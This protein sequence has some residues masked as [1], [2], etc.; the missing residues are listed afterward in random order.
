MK[1]PPP[2]SVSGTW[3][4][5]LFTVITAAASAVESGAT[6]TLTG[7]VSNEGTGAFLPGALVRIDG[8]D[9]S[10][11]TERDGSYLLQVPP[12]THT[13]VASFSGLD[14]QSVLVTTGTGAASVLNFPLTSA[15]YKMAKFVV[16]SEREG[17]ALALTLQRQADNVKNV[18][19]SD[20][21]GSLAGNPG[22]LLQRVPGV[23]AEHVGGDIRY[24]SIRGINPDLSA[25][26]IDGNRSASISPDR[27]GWF[28]NLNADPI[29]SMEVIKAPTPD[30]DADSIGGTINLRS[31]SGFDVKGRRITYSLGGTIAVRRDRPH[32]AVT[33]SYADVVGKEERLGVSFTAGFREYLAVMDDTIH[34]FQNTDADPAYQWRLETVERKNLRGRWGGGLKLDYK[35]SSEAS[36]FTNFTYA[37]NSEDNFVITHRTATAQTVATLN[38][39]GAPTGTGA[40]L[41]NFTATRTEARP[42]AASIAE[43]INLHRERTATVYTAQAGGR[44]RSPR[45][46]VD[47]DGSYSYGEHF[48]HFNRVT[49][50][51]RGVGWVLDRTDRSRWTPTVTQI[52]GPDTTNLDNYTSNVFDSVRPNVENTIYGAQF[53]Y[54]RK[55]DFTWPSY[56]KTGL[57]F[58][59]EENQRSNRDRRWNHVGPDGTMGT[60]DDR[61]SQF[62]DAN[63]NHGHFRGFYAARPIPSVDAMRDDISAS[64][65][66][67]SED[68]LHS[69]TQSIANNLYAE[70]DVRAAYVLGHTKAGRL[71]MLAGARMEDTTVSGEGPVQHLTAEERARRAA[72]FGPVTQTEGIRRMLAERGGRES[73]SNDYRHVF[74]SLHFKYEPRPGL[75]GRLSYT[76]GIGRPN[77]NT[78]TP[79]LQVN[80]D[81]L[82]VVANNPGIKPQYSDNF[83]A[84]IEYYFEPVGVVS[85]GVF[86]KE[87]SDF[88]FTAGGTVIGAG[89]DNG[90]GGEYQ[91]YELRTQRNGGS[92]R[93]RGLE[94]N[95]QQQFT[96]L[97]GWLKGFG[98]LANYTKLETKGDYGS[99]GNV[100][101]T[102]DVTG[103]TPS[104][105]NV[106]I[107]YILGKY[108]FRIAY[109]YKDQKLMAFNALVNRR[110]YEVASNRVDLKL[111]YLVTRNLDL[112]LDLYN[113]F[114]DKQCEVWGFDRPRY[115]RDRNDPQIH[116]GVNGRF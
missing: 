74:P 82:V 38:A 14:A 33:F 108:N 58:R 31:R 64:P 35:L 29:E 42:V 61:L 7:R 26:Q 72:W 66:R 103:F 44:I 24:L 40:I 37:P 65:T 90:F 80:E 25:I 17:H 6:A 56:V 59:H 88:M 78:V 113:V 32:P 92:A 106:G 94:L 67:W 4:T 15:I 105:G 115:V 45:S 107:S 99:I 98:L 54:R 97:P 83:D 19:S 22:E 62:R 93:V 100:Q 1:R 112:Y 71:S 101:S 87:I 51:A 104:T 55:L 48:D 43:I 79:N 28:E 75:L 47:Y 53:N 109:N 110:R 102:A 39:Q 76:S 9:A 114:N 21:F 49:V 84:S 85:A 20:A 52:S 89:P 57:K 2:Y 3:L 30:M 69:Y 60:A 68:V 27:R 10:T 41:P 96:F 5:L 111:R 73:Q 16:S 13:V 63:Y 36:L 34:D 86:L 50:T 81:T 77:F 91:G 70:E 46:E 18:V 95:Y 8:L 12:G 23:I 11:T 116:A